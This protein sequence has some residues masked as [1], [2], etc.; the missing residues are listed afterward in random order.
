MVYAYVRYSTDKQTNQQQLEKIR[1]YCEF[2]KIKVNKV[3][4][5]EETSG[6]VAY[7]DRS[8]YD[9]IGQMKKG[10]TIIVSEQ[11]RL[12]RSIFDFSDILR[13]VIVKK[14][15]CIILCD[16]NKVYDGGNLD[17]LTQMEL[18]FLAG[19]SQMERELISSRT[20]AALAAR[21]RSGG[22]F[23]KAGI[24]R[25]RL[26]AP[27]GRNTSKA[28]NVCIENKRDKIRNSKECRLM[29]D[30]I[31]EL[32][33]KGRRWIDVAEIL[34]K[35][36]LLRESGI[37]WTTTSVYKYYQS[38]DKVFITKINYHEMAMD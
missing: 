32:R 24:W 10:D 1:Q 36:N 33:H 28:R 25:T 34:N 18:S 31:S 37:P 21:K 27:S 9:L 29:Y 6:T 12:S 22:W 20:K 16:R 7:T 2:A 35:E 15:G 23:S 11:S 3:I 19:A 17:A 30:K 5:D 13:E 38:L 26:G 14:E 8:L 4:S